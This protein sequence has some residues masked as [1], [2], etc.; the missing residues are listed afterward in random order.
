M[1]LQL[2]CFLHPQKLGINLCKYDEMACLIRGV[3]YLCI[4]YPQECYYWKNPK[5][6]DKAEKV[7]FPLGPDP[8]PYIIVNIGSGIS[9]L[10]VKSAEKFKRIGGTSVGGGTF[11]GLSLLSSGNMTSMTQQTEYKL[12]LM[13]R[14]INKNERHH[15]NAEQV[16]RCKV[17]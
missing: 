17:M 14:I 12:L 13:R 16:Q 3:H 11:V 15:Y 9:V 8:Y 10:L 7:P 4:H 2:A 5:V 6:K 1:P